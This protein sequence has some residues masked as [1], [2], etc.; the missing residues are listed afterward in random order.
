M[1]VLNDRFGYIGLRHV[2]IFLVKVIRD[3]TLTTLVI[4]IHTEG[5]RD[6]KLILLPLLAA[7]S[8]AVPLASAHTGLPNCFG[9]NMVLQQKQANKVWGWGDAGEGITLTIGKQTKRATV[10]SNGAWHVML[11]PMTAGGPHTMTIEGQEA[12]VFENVLI[13]EVWVCSG[14]SNMEWPVALSDNADLTTMTAHYP[15]I[16]FLSVPQVG[17]EEPQENFKGSWTVCTPQSTDQFSAVGY[18]FGRQLHQSLGVPIGLIDN[19]W[20]GSACEAWVNRDLLEKDPRLKELMATWRKTEDFYKSGKAA[21][22]HAIK[23]ASWEKQAAKAKTEGK[24]APSKPRW[25]N[26]VMTGNQRPANIYNGVLHPTIGYGIKGAIWYQGESNTSRA[27]QYRDLFPLMIKNWRDEWGQGDFPFYWVQLADF[28]VELDMPAD[29]DW[30]ELREAQTMTMNKLPNTGQAVIIDI[31]EADDIHPT[32]KREVGNRLARWALAN[33][34]GYS[35]LTYQNPLYRSMKKQDNA[36]VVSFDHT[37]KGL[38]T[39][40]LPQVKGFTI[41]GK[42]K[43]FH[44]AE[45]QILGIGVDRKQVKVWSDHVK[46]PVAVRYAWADNPVCNVRNYDGLPLTPFRTD[47]WPGVTAYVKTL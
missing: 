37:S 30:A 5:M 42:D 4:A 20:G 24:S 35:N 45:A 9:S 19:A 10:D 15:N 17:T 27:Y 6:F 8:L 40:D 39:F 2:H 29:S 36:I 38:D 12:I 22:Q 7:T 41:A 32:N 43:V 44:H 14:Q 16:R 46:N 3:Q 31:G 13:G 33:D 25:D 1:T 34:Y 28:K 18:N 21:E 11:D 26:L 23:L 47:D